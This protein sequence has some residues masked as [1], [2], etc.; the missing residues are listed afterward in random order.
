MN[1]RLIEAILDRYIA[2]A[3]QRQKDWSRV[4]VEAAC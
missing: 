3:Q 2:K 1:V 4:E